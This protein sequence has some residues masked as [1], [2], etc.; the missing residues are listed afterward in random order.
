M[1]CLS[2]WAPEWS[3]GPHCAR[4]PQ[5]GSLWPTALLLG[6]GPGLGQAPEVHLVADWRRPPVGLPTG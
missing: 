4:E 6:P 5:T 1:A 3:L 2:A